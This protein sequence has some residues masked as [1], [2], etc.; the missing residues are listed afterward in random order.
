[1]FKHKYTIQF[2][3]ILEKTYQFLI[4]DSDDFAGSVTELIVANQPVM[5]YLKGDKDVM[6]DRILMSECRVK[7]ESL[8]NYQFLD[9]FTANSKR[10][11]GICTLNGNP[12]W[13]GFLTP[14]YYQEPFV[15]PPYEV[16]LLFTDGLGTLKNI[17]FNILEDFDHDMTL[18]EINTY[19]PLDL[20]KKSLWYQIEWILRKIGYVLDIDEAL[21][22]Y[23]EN[24][25]QDKNPAQQVYCKT[26][27]WYNDK[28]FMKC[29]DVLDEI[30][31]A[32]GNAQLI[33]S[34]NKWKITSLN[35]RKTSHLTRH[36]R[37]SEEI[38]AASIYDPLIPITD[39][40]QLPEDQNFFWTDA[41]LS[42]L[43]AWKKFIVK[44][45][46][47][48]D[49]NIFD[50]MAYI[51]QGNTGVSENVDLLGNGSVIKDL[52]FYTLNPNLS[53]S[54]NDFLLYKLGSIT[55]SD[56]DILKINI[57]T[58]FTLGHVRIYIKVANDK[59][60][61]SDQGQWHLND[62][63]NISLGTEIG[64]QLDLTL[65]SD[66]IPITG[67]LYVQLI[68]RNYVGRGDSLPCDLDKGDIIIT[69]ESYKKQYEEL[70]METDINEGQNYVPD[71][72]TM[73]LGDLP[74]FENVDIMYNGGL[75]RAEPVYLGGGDENIA[76]YNFYPT[77]LWV[78]KESTEKKHLI[79]LIAD[80][81]SMNHLRP[82]M[83]IS[84][85]LHC[86][87]KP[88]S[89]VLLK[90]NENKLFICKRF[91]ED[92]YSDDWDCDLVEIGRTDQGYLKLR[93]DGYIILRGG[94]KIKIR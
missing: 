24:M 77:N 25:D 48:Y 20:N 45:D 91:T 64:K 35:N 50:L 14:D 9:F 40:Y 46:F 38:E 39:Q 6:E 63:Y 21:Y 17:D 7:V 19:R 87:F 61:L 60:Y 41:G 94:G 85:S 93:S 47:G 88:D 71:D 2:T 56:Y 75:Y 44:Q 80:E 4:Y 83:M 72:Y 82:Q 67:D 90:V 33:Q 62:V 42:I 49:E 22:V 58:H 53:H 89:T 11:K 65:T 8:T 74:N 51:K 81:I 55:K 43:P 1:M 70:T 15:S 3:S 18:A 34:E 79:N 86:N 10:Y 52:R 12:I 54:D 5:R 66:T 13:T 28:G 27:N 23:E 69:M 26:T 57:N 78:V 31:K 76:Y 68:T 16:E 29:F 73:M 32:L 30:L 92:M 37:N 59:Y 36:F 84:G